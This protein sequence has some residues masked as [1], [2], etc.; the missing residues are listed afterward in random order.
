[1]WGGGDE[2]GGGRESRRLEVPH[3][4][5]LGQAVGTGQLPPP[6]ALLPWRPWPG[7]RQD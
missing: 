6:F 5:A 1:M 7:N 3:L 4:H 2:G